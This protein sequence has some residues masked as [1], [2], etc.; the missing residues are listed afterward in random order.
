[1]NASDLVL[2]CERTRCRA[3]EAGDI[4]CI[5]AM[6]DQDLV[7]VHGPGTVH[8]KRQLLEFLR[9]SVR[10]LSVQR[11]GLCVRLE[12]D[13]AWMTGLMKLRGTRVVTG[14]QITATTF[15]TQIWRLHQGECRLVALQ[16]TGVTD[17]LWV[18]CMGQ[19]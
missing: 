2:E 9:T 16:S 13:I 17:S 19:Q 6:L 5:E 4:A 15:V 7:Y 11:C 14:E 12:G 3:L 1:M 8:D 10:Y 18:N